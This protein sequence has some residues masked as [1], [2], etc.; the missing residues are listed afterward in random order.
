MRALVDSNIETV[1]LQHFIQTGINID[2]NDSNG[3]RT[4]LGSCGAE[5][6]DIHA[7]KSGF[8]R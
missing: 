2:E 1:K 8:D 4:Q 3:L 5:A 6:F 7:T